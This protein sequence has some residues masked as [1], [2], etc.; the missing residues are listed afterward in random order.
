MGR[1]KKEIREDISESKPGPIKNLSLEK[2]HMLVSFKGKRLGRG[3]FIKNTLWVARDLLGKYVVRKI[4][5]RVKVGKIVETEAY[6]GP[7]DRA[8]H[9][10]NWKRTPRNEAE[11]L[12]GGFLYVYLCYGVHWQLNIVT[13]KKGKPECVLIRALEPVKKEDREKKIA[14]GPGKLTKWLKIDKSFDKEDLTKSKKIWIE[15]WGERL[16]R[17][18]IIATERIGIDYAEEW[19]KVP[20]RFYI[21]NNPFVSRR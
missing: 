5:D 12:E 18:D 8:S 7:Q 15:D 20:W 19:V 9:A 10:F 21:K 16:K 4:G 6:I 11:Y 3:F 1:A 2:E 14:S 17:E 13:Y